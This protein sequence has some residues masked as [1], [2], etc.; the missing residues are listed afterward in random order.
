MVNILI[1]LPTYLPTYCQC[2]YLSPIL[3]LPII[4]LFSTYPPISYLT[5]NLCITKLKPTY[6]PTYHLL[7]FLHIY[8]LPPYLQPIYLCDQ[9]TIK[10]YTLDERMRKV[11]HVITYI[12]IQSCMHH[13][14]V[15]ISGDLYIYML[16]D[17]KSPK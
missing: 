16:R 2:T 3:N 17:I 4:H 9:N 14:E 12:H 13:N 11:I 5:I 7:A 10:G 6:L 1:H 15:D 8:L